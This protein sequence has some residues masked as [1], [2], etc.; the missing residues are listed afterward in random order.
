MN[1][2]KAVIVNMLPESWEYVLRK[3]KILIKYINGV[4][5]SLDYRTKGTKKLSNGKPAWKN[6]VIVIKGLFTNNN[7][8]EY[9][10]NSNYAE[11]IGDYDF[12]NKLSYEVQEYE[13][14]HK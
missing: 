3:N 9:C 14:Y 4:Y 13:F 10:L 7:R 1:G 5:Q 11:K 12:W 8:M 2:L 6:G